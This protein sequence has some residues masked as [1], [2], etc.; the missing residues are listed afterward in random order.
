M[1]R[2]V[3]NKGR[4]THFSRTPYQFSE[5]LGSS[6]LQSRHKYCG[7]RRGHVYALT[8]SMWSAGIRQDSQSL[9]T[10]L[11]FA[12][13]HHRPQETFGLCISHWTRKLKSYPVMFAQTPSLS[14][15]ASSLQSLAFNDFHEYSENTDTDGCPYE[16]I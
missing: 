4:F 6:L 9:A 5:L 14:N 1:R 3:K 16:V 12:N 13:H 2:N 11:F 10:R 7:K 8:S 15:P